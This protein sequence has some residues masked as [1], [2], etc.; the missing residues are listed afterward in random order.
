[1]AQPDQIAGAEAPK[2]YD[3]TVCRR[4]IEHVLM[5]ACRDASF[6]YKVYTYLHPEMLNLDEEVEYKFIWETMVDYY[7]A[8]ERLPSYT[9]LNAEVSAR[10]H[11]ASWANDEIIQAAERVV[12]WMFSLQENPTESLDFDRALTYLQDILYDRKVGQFVRSTVD[13]AG[14]CSIPEL[15]TLLDSWQES[16]RSIRVVNDEL[17]QDS[18]EDQSERLDEPILPCG[19]TMLDNYMHGGSHPGEVQ[20][21]LGPIGVGKTTL[22]VQI[23]VKS[24][25]LQ[26]EFE[27]KTPNS[28]GISVFFSY[29]DNLRQLRVRALAC[30]AD[31]DKERLDAVYPNYK[32]LST[33]DSLED[34]ERAKWRKQLAQHHRVPG[35]QE[36]KQAC[37]AWMNRHLHLIDFSPSRTYNKSGKGHHGVPEKR[38]VLDELRRRTNRHIAC[39]VDDHAG[40]CVRNYLNAAGI[41]I[42][43][44]NLITYLGDY[45]SQMANHIAGPFGCP[46]FVMHQLKGQVLG[47][48]AGSK[49]HHSDA[50]WCSMFAEAAQYAFCLSNKDDLHNAC[51]LY[52]TK[53]RRSEPHPPQVCQITHFNTLEPAQEYL[54]LDATTQ[55]IVPKREADRY[56]GNVSSG[57]AVPTGQ[58]TKVDV[59]Q[60]VT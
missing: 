35:E 44:Q 37:E 38:T 26:H 33:S 29:E 12:Y 8:N 16:I 53:S 22:G 31:I 13:R 49:V 51:M 45:I 24:A 6:F 59:D 14:N 19:V 54:R 18:L 39:V 7:T 55:R 11:G 56:A 32:L 57:S 52:C 1:M 21:V 15:P 9:T 30:A 3:R 60:M 25:Q 23:C 41:P 48:S 28:G 47:K 27:K 42:T 43:P 50:A 34:Y 40:V 17:F 46:T 20:A 10:L 2:T 36:R 58:R 4:T 5:H